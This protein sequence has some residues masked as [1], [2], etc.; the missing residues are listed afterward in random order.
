MA[1]QWL[2]IRPGIS[3]RPPPAITVAPASAAIGAVEMRSMTLPRTSTLEGADSA[4]LLP[5]NTRTF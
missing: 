2:S 5:S 4:L 3:V 1:C